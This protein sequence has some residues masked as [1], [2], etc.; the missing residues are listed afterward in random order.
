M[1]ETK[2][3]KSQGDKEYDLITK[4]AED[5]H[6]RVEALLGRDVDILV[7]AHRP[8]NEGGCRTTAST[9]LNLSE[10]TQEAHDRLVRHLIEEGTNI[11]LG[12]DRHAGPTRVE[13]K[14]KVH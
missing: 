5:F 8:N 7:I 11:V 10:D 9:H 4:E 12:E 1:A 3:Q 6:A 2:S 13:V 14:G